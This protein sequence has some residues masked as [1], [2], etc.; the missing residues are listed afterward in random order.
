MMLVLSVYSKVLNCWG[1][2]RSTGRR[3]LLGALSLSMAT[4]TTPVTA[5]RSPTTLQDVNGHWAQMCIQHLYRRKIL[6]GYPDQTFRP[7]Q[8]VTRTEFAAMIDRAFSELPDRTAQREYGDLDETYWGLI[9][10]ARATQTGFLEGYPDGTFAPT[11][12]I[13]RYEVLLALVSGLNYSPQ[14]NP[15]SIIRQYYEDANL[16]PSFAYRAIAAATEQ[17]L[18][19]NYPNVRQL[20]PQQ[21]AS[22]AEV[23]SFLCRALKTTGTV[24]IQYIVGGDRPIPVQKPSPRPA[25]LPNLEG[26]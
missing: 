18:V 12:N 6:T 11:K 9:P 19:V 7:N 10:I 3:L 16:L 4:M 13:P 23:S 24:P 20:Q 26:F 17:Q 8:P 2:R 1:D 15:Q 22:R 14:G 5:Q 25:T 21:W